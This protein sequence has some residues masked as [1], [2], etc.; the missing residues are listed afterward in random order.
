MTKIIARLGDLGLGLAG[1]SIL[2]MMVIGAADIVGTKCCDRPLPAMLEATESLMVFAVFFALAKTQADRQHIRV[3]L[4]TMRLGSTA[5]EFFDVL[6]LIFALGVFGLIAW[7]GWVLAVQ[8]WDVREYAEGIVQF[9]VYP[10]K[11]ALALG[12]T[13]ATVQT[14]WDTF[15]RIRRSVQG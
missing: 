14:I 11:F 8:S 1:V 12:A 7:R 15:S 3:E 6:A 13:L 4:V 9:P 2:V 5:R 10:S